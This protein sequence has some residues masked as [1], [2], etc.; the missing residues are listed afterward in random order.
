LLIWL[1]HAG[2]D[3][4]LVFHALL[5]LRKEIREKNEREDK[6]R[7]GTPNAQSEHFAHPQLVVMV[8]LLLLSHGHVRSSFLAHK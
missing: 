3:F 8:L 6:E 2:L 1:L 5:S 4:A 7:H